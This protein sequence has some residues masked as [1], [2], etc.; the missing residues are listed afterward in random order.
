M[1]RCGERICHSAGRYWTY[2]TVLGEQNT[3]VI[4]QAVLDHYSTCGIDFWN[5]CRGFLGTTQ[6]IG[7]YRP[8]TLDYQATNYYSRESYTNLSL[9]C[10]LGVQYNS[11]A[12]GYAHDISLHASMPMACFSLM[13]T[14][15]SNTYAG[16]TTFWS[17]GGKVSTSGTKVGWIMIVAEGKDTDKNVLTSVAGSTKGDYTYQDVKDE[18]E[19]KNKSYLYTMG[20]K[21]NLVA[22]E[23]K[24][25]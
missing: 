11:R 14:T 8:T 22:P 1:V 7:H 10:D 24:A 6:G 16:V 18:R 12:V 21:L 15:V 9:A 25:A 3:P 20:N 5:Y 2:D 17:Q 19:T 4:K 13:D 23:A